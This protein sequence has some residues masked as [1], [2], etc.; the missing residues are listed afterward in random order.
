VER[1]AIGERIRDALTAKRHRGERTSRHAPIGFRFTAAGR[2]EPNAK[3]QNQL[4]VVADCRR[5]GFAWQK[6]ADELARLG[7][8]ARS[9][10]P[11]TRWNVRA[12]YQTAI[13]QGTIDAS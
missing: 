7:Y 1:E 13:R 12:V 5:S 8:K 3:E 4:A 9:G 10:R 11:W 6:I 2:L